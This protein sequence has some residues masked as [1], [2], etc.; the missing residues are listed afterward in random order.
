MLFDD[1]HASE[2]TVLAS[3][4]LTLQCTDVQAVVGFGVIEVEGPAVPFDNGGSGFCTEAGVLWGS[5]PLFGGVLA[6]AGDGP[7]VCFVERDEDSHVHG[8]P[9]AEDGVGVEAVGVDRHVRPVD[10]VSHNGTSI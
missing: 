8:V 3:D 7:L 2:G 9:C 6:E 10:R 5:G 1:P 4:P